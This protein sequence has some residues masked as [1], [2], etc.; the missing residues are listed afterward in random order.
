VTLADCGLSRHAL[1]IIAK[2]IIAKQ[3]IAKQIIV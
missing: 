1:Q 3:I 2:Q